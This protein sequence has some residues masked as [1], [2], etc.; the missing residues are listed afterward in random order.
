MAVFPDCMQRV[1]FVFVYQRIDPRARDVSSRQLS[2]TLFSL[3]TFGFLYKLLM[4]Y[5]TLSQQNTIQVFGLCLYSIIMCIYNAT[6][7]QILKEGIAV[8]ADN[9]VI[10]EDTS[11][12]IR[13]I[14]I[15][16]IV[17]TTSFTLW[18][19]P[20]AWKVYDEF[21][22]VTFRQVEGDLNMRRRFLHFQ[23]H[24]VLTE[25]TP[26]D[27]D[28]CNQ[29]FISLLKFGGFYSLG[30]LVQP[31]VMTANQVGRFYSII[32]ATFFIVSATL[33]P[34]SVCLL[35]A[36]AWVV[37]HEKRRGT[38]VII[39]SIDPENIFLYAICCH[40]F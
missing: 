5:D 11:P 38:I 23:V 26:L 16:I 33:I 13:G 31:V 14:V 8:L 28:L 3:V 18:M 2:P 22:W 6:Q 1:I 27:A 15:S 24:D 10:R 29:L 12:V 9:D 36:S 7:Y 40:L 35:F 32:S 17:V 19:F 39:V 21:A 25:T 4:L 34:I 20:L 37:R 30:F